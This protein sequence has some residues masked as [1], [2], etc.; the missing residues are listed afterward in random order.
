MQVLAKAV[1]FPVY[2]TPLPSSY[3][4]AYN[5]STQI[6]VFVFLST[7]LYFVLIRENILGLHQFLIV[8]Y[9]YKDNN[10][11]FQYVTYFIK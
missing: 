2:I 7:Q 8:C 11:F 1:H 10:V 6:F 5:N 4:Y 3:M 9:N